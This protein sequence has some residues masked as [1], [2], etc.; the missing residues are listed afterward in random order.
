MQLLVC[1]MLFLKSMASDS[2]KELSE[3]CFS[4]AKIENLCLD[5]VLPGYPEYCFKS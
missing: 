1:R 3:S 4:D 2:I 5:F